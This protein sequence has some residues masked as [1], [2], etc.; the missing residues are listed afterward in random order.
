MLSE[1][2][3]IFLWFRNNL[4]DRFSRG[5]VN[6][7]GLNEMSSTYV[8]EQETS[9]CTGNLIQAVRTECAQRQTRLQRTGCR[10]PCALLHAGRLG[11]RGGET[12]Q[13]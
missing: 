6:V 11:E 12:G 4:S 10:R 1:F 8:G 13:Q 9:L 7:N 5:G 3:L 2:G